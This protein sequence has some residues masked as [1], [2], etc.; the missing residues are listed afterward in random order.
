MN[1]FYNNGSQ[2]I[3]KGLKLKGNAFDK[4]LLSLIKND[5]LLEK[6]EQE[7]FRV[8]DSNTEYARTISTILQMIEQEIAINKV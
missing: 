6:L 4:E 2:L 3:D 1:F 5:E 8:C 7:F